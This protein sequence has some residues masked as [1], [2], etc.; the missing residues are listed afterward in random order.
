MIQSVPAL[1]ARG[2]RTLV[3][4]AE[5]RAEAIGVAV[6]IVVCDR[7]G[8]P[9][10]LLRMDGAPKFSLTVAQKKAWTAAAAGAA[11]VHLRDAFLADPALLHALG[12]HVD[13]LMTLAGRVSEESLNVIKADAG[14]PE[15]LRT[16]GE[17]KLS[18]EDL[19]KLLPSEPKKGK[20][21]LMP[22]SVLSGRAS[23]FS[24]R[25]ARTGRRL[26]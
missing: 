23:T 3:D 9:L 17:R 18:A 13:E 12:T 1:T 26:W 24:S 4:A 7:S 22:Y 14:M 2:A 16:V 6:V 20:R 8:D 25:R 15:F 11:T 10:A 5:A 21:A 19:M